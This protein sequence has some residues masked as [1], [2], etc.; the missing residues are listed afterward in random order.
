MTKLYVNDE[1]TLF[2]GTNETR[3]RYLLSAT[4]LLASFLS[5]QHVLQYL[6]QHTYAKN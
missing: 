1:I 3:Y 6:V 4:I 5:V 2:D